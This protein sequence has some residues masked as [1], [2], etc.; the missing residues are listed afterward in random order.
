MKQRYGTDLRLEKVTSK[1]L[2]SW[3]SRVEEALDDSLKKLGLEYVDC[4]SNI[5]PSSWLEWMLTLMRSVLD[6]LADSVEPEGYTT[7]DSSASRRHA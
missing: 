3:H 6:A 4:M 5:Q 1:V 7:T 2:G